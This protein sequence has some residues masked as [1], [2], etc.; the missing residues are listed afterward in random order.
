[1]STP[2]CHECQKFFIINGSADEAMKVIEI[3]QGMYY[4]R[5]NDE[6]DVLLARIVQH[7]NRGNRTCVNPVERNILD[8]AECIYQGSFLQ[9]NS[10]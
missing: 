4:L 6:L 10:Y 5:G 1:M 8:T 3:V 7:G 9:K 2:R